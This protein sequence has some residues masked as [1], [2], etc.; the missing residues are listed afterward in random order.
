M[1]I[2]ITLPVVFRYQDLHLKVLKQDGIQNSP[3]DD[4]IECWPLKLN[5]ILMKYDG[6]NGELNGILLNK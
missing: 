1:F 3:S 2:D 6:T 4:R 5:F